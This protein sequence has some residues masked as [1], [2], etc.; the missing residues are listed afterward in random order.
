MTEEDRLREAVRQHRLAVGQAYGI[1]S[2]QRLHVVNM[3][4][5]E[6]AGVLAGQMS[7]EEVVSEDRAEQEEEAVWARVHRPAMLENDD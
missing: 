5:W 6:A 4:L 2:F 3:E 1:G 7:V